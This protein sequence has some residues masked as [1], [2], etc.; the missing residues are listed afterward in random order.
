MDQGNTDKAIDFYKKALSIQERINDLMGVAISYNNLG[1]L[2][3]DSNEIAKALEYYTQGLKVSREI[4]DLPGVSAGLAGLGVL[5]MSQGDSARS[6][7]NSTLAAERYSK[8]VDCLKESIA[9]DQKLDNRI[10]VA[11]SLKYTWLRE[12]FRVHWN[13]AT[14]SFSSCL[15][16][17]NAWWSCERRSFLNQIAVFAIPL[18]QL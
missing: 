7:Q 17:C 8:A 18:K 3:Q 12:T 1:S 4:G 14:R 10:R 11:Y 13:P 9:I 16:R 5:C 2:Y 6:N 15:P